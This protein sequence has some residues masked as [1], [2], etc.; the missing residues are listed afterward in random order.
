MTLQDLHL[1][2][3]YDSDKDSLLLD[4]YIPALC[5]SISYKR[6]AGYFSS[7]SLAISAR[8]ISGLINNGGNIQLI[9][10][11]V[12]SEDDQE[13]IKEVIYQKEQ[14][15]LSEI[16]SMEDVIKKGHLKM[17]AWL[18]KNGKLEIKIAKVNNGLEHKKKGILE[19]FE[20]N[21]V[22][23]SGSDNETVSGWLHNHEDFHVF[24]SW[25]DGDFERHLEPDL[26][27][28][29]KLWDNETNKVTVYEISEAF[30]RGF[31]KNAP[32]DEAEFQTLSHEMVQRMNKQYSIS[33]S[34]MSL[35]EEPSRYT[36]SKYLR[37]YQEE[38]IEKWELNG[39]QGILKMATGTG[40]TFTAINAI[41]RY[42]SRQ[43]EGFVVIVAPKQLLV[44][45]WSDELKKLGY[46][47]VVEVMKDSSKWE[48]E[49]K[50][51]LLK[52]ELGREK[53]VFAVATYASFSSEKFK[54]II[55]SVNNNVL[56]VCDEMHNSWA[57]EYKKGFLGKY[58][59]KLGLSATPERYM[60]DGGTQE[61]LEYFG[62]VVFEFSLKDAIPM[63]LTEY[64]YHAELVHLTSEEKYEYDASTST[65]SKMIAANDGKINEKILLKILQRARIVT[66]SESKWDA[67]DKILDSISDIKKTLVYCSPQQ[68]EKVMTMLRYRKIPTHKITYKEPLKFRKEI[69]EKFI[70]DNYRVIVAIKV[71]DEGIDVPGIERAIILANS[72]NPIEYVQRRGR[73]LRKSPGKDFSIIHDIL[74]FPWEDIPSTISNSDISMIKKELFR[75][76]EFSKASVNPLEVLNQISHYYRLVEDW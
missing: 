56:L 57:P 40:K 58:Q 6:I 72:G 39:C 47:N 7:N 32:K 23:F 16:D 11:V 45:Q 64:E 51:S 9:A 55:D 37:D 49:L 1:K 35:K 20:G 41:E 26:E 43:N 48:K 28:F 14:E 60:D 42:L 63:F 53:E 75:I 13:T 46:S 22:S 44:S 38:A 18:L 12:L 21:V 19:D 65:I 54:S 31:I 62:G 30:K 67:F 3:F 34:S 66:N 17:L 27:S 68:I 29:Q 70:D 2:G 74:V 8:G 15:I 5:E 52:M 25:I 10:N 76:E 4:F 73:I 24:C 33:S 69:I 59:K 50:A 36:L 61:M 71:L